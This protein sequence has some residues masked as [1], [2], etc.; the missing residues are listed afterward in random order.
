ME[1]K[2]I[3]IHGMSIVIKE[4]NHNFTAHLLSN[5][6]IW[7]IGKNEKEAIGDLVIT[8]NSLYPK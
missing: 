6:G 8:I 1:N 4:M 5:P 2:T 3:K 7:G